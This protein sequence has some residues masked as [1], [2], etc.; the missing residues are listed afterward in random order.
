MRHRHVARILL[1]VGLVVAVP[2]RAGAQ[3][4]GIKGGVQFT[5]VAWG[6]QV[7]LNT[8]WGWGAM[9]GMF[10]RLQPAKAIPLQIEALVTQLV[11][12]FSS[13]GAD[14]KHTLTNLQVPVMV[15]Y[16]V[17]SGSSSLV[18]VQGGAAFDLL[19]LA[20]E[21]VSGA[22]SDIRESVAPWGASLVVAGEFEK[23][24]WV[25]DARYVFGLTEIYSSEVSAD[26]P[27]RQ[28]AIQ[29]TAGWRF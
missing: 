4:Y 12:D 27:A 24:R 28:R 8:P 5:D 13:E 10:M 17:V 22:K 15:R 20:R 21:D 26:F 9:G 2:G 11:V 19:L 7:V 23:G 6:D 3:E 29:A 14:V 18:R 25:F 1:V 16:T